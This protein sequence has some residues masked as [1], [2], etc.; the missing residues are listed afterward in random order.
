MRRAIFRTILG[1]ALAAV[2]AAVG[3]SA[4]SQRSDRVTAYTRPL[5][6]SVLGTFVIRERQVDLLV[7]WRDAPGWF[8][9][10][11]ERRATYGGPLGTFRASLSYGGVPLEFE[12]HRERH[13]AAVGGRQASLAEG[14]NVVLV[15][16]VAGPTAQ[17]T[18]T[19]VA[20]DL[21]SQS[22]NPPV[23]EILGRSSEIRAFL[24]CERE[25][26]QR[27]ASPAAAYVCEDLERK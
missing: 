6:P 9:R 7:L 17:Q 26:P 10:G 21:R 19:M 2:V 13:A 12:Y 25:A 1:A 16:R 11:D 20:A 27:S 8:L 24:A 23:A 14:R 22:D 5:S 15:D 3:A 4:Q 18:V